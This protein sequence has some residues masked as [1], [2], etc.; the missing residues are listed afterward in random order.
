MKGIKLLYWFKSYGDFAEW[1]DFAYW[2]SFI[3][4]GLHLQPAQPAC[5]FLFCIQNLRNI[6][7]L[8]YSTTA[9]IGCKHTNSLLKCISFL[10]TFGR[11]GTLNDSL[12]WFDWS[13][14][15]SAINNSC[16]AYSGFAKVKLN[17]SCAGSYGQTKP[18]P[19][20]PTF[21]I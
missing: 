18:V 9:S 3:G 13:T 14:G 17:S 20:E 5:L 4:K 2:W 11:K 6:R 1:V 16:L 19:G 12:C 15:K 21:G 8:E 7:K 10:N